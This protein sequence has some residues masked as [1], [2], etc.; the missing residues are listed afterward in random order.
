VDHQ[1]TP[2]HLS[3]CSSQKEKRYLTAIFISQV[4][5]HHD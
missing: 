2:S 1:P 5:G 4:V 3:K